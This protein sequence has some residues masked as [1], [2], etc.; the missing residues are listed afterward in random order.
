MLSGGIDQ[1]IITAG[2]IGQI[3][4]PLK[5]RDR[6]REIDTTVEALEEERVALAQQLE[7]EGFQLIAAKVKQDEDMGDWRN[8]REGDLLTLIEDSSRDDFTRGKEYEF[9]EVDDFDEIVVLDDA[10][11]QNGYGVNSGMFKFHS[12]P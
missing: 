5:W 7:D 8:W 6:I 4:G 10:G 11:D 12:R 9:I 2:K 3:D 1:T